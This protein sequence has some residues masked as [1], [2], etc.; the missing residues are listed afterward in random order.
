MKKTV[1]KVRETAIT[2]LVALLLSGCAAV[3]VPQEE[4]LVNTAG[5]PGMHK[6]EELA[7]E[8]SRTDPKAQEENIP[9]TLFEGRLYTLYVPD[10]GW[11]M[12]A[13]EAWRAEANPAVQFWVTDYA[14]TDVSIVCEQLANAAGYKPTEEDC[15]LLHY[16]D[17]DLS[18]W[19][20]KLF[21]ENGETVGVFY[22]YPVEVEED[23]GVR[24]R[25]IVDTFAWKLG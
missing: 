1:Q 20:V 14:G 24:L 18:V 22:C 3:E 6:G 25:A 11:E 17:K 9:T 7:K 5:I 19:N 10:E 15:Y 2:M 12:Y 23:F 21:T 4:L 8:K 16:E 13:T